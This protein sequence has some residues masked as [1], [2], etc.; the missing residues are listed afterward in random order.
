MKLNYENGILCWKSC[1]LSYIALCVMP[2]YA[3]YAQIYPA[4]VGTTNWTPT[5]E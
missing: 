2:I 1:L 4:I 5:N 3:Y